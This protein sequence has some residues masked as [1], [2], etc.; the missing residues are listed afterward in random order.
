MKNN[1]ASGLDLR[2]E[3]FGLRDVGKGI[4]SLNNIVHN[5]FFTQNGRKA[6]SGVY[7]TYPF[8]GIW[9]EEW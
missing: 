5:C 9:M 1:N 8:S 7:W 2:L 3:R 4:M 6:C